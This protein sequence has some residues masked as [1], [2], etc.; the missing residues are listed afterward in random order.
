MLGV[1]KREVLIWLMGHKVA[2]KSIEL[3]TVLNSDQARI[4]VIK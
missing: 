4:F 2:L 1:D 3:E